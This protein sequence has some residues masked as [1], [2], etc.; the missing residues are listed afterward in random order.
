MLLVQISDVHCGP[1][2]NHDV[3]LTAVKEINAL[4]PDLIVITGDLTDEGIRSESNKQNK[5]LV[6]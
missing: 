4:S 3:F 6:D 2:F 1:M 5:N